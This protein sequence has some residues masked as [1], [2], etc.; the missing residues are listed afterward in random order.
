M[1]KLN[2]L[3]LAVLTLAAGVTLAAAQT[4]QDRT[5]HHP[6]GQAPAMG[7]RAGG[8][9]MQGQSRGMGM[10]GG[11]MMQM[12]AMMQMM[13]DGAMPMGMMGPEA[14]PSHVEGRIA[15]MKAELKIT[16]A[17]TPQWNAFADA[18]RN[19]ATTMRGAMMPMMQASAAAPAPDLMERRIAIMSSHLDAAKAMLAAFKP[20]YASLTD[21]QKKAAD[22]LLAEHMMAMRG[23]GM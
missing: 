19:S 8:M 10:M 20:L 22:E 15:F 13:R 5:A 18:L 12:M 6:D 7:G 9:P 23:R 4:T 21:E 16:D 3:T 14:M 2:T 1:H 17:Q 11:N